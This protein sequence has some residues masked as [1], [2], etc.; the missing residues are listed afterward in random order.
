ML[1]APAYNSQMVTEW[2]TQKFG[3][4]SHTASKYWESDADIKPPNKTLQQCPDIAKQLIH[5]E[6][7]QNFHVIMG[8]GR[9]K[10][11]PKTTTDEEGGLG[12]RL[13]N[14]NLIEEWKEIKEKDQK[15][16]EYIWNRKQLMEVKNDTDYL[17]GLFDNDMCKYNVDRDPEMDPTLEEMT[18]AAIKRLQ[19][20]EKGYFLFVEGGMIDQAHHDNKA[21]KAL[22]ETAEFSKAIRKAVEMTNEQDTL[23]VVTADHSHT[24][25]IGSYPKRGSDVLGLSNIYD[26]FK[27]KEIIPILTYANGPGQE[28]TVN[29][30]I[31]DYSKDNID[32][33]YKYPVT[34]KT[35]Q[36]THGG[37]DVLIYARGPWAHLFGGVM[38][39]N[40]IPHLMA[41]ASCVGDKS[42]ACKD[43]ATS[44]GNGVLPNPK[45]FEVITCLQLLLTVIY[46]KQYI[47]IFYEL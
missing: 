19:K 40:A 13:D 15:K 37:D 3:L 11:L 4:Y 2:L 20:S 26:L 34:Y 33:N 44:T 39:Q 47:N 14:K 24:M 12:H 1:D 45:T 28:H 30:S 21:G 31:Y 17:F 36:E 8:C 10:F 6:L 27:F 22:D 38:E 16:H 42:T 9:N 41:Y 43:G 32:M 18:E 23:I 5:S 46:C 7:G 29:G 25:V 35:T